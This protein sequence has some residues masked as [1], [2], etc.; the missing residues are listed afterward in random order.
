MANDLSPAAGAP[1][2]ATAGAPAAATAGAPATAAA[3]AG[4]P[5]TP[6]APRTPMPV[7]SLKRSLGRHRRRLACVLAALAAL[8]AVLA[9]AEIMLGNT[10]YPVRTVLDVLGGAQVTGAAYAIWEVRLPR[11]AAGVLAGFAFG[12]AGNTFQTMLRN[13]LASPDVIGITSGASVV[14]VACILV[15]H[16][17]AASA[18]LWAVLGGVLTAAAIFALATIGGFSI[19]KF[20]LVGLGVQAFMKAVVSYLL[21][22]GAEFDV[23]VALRWL[24]GSLS[25]TTMDDVGLLVAVVIPLA[26]LVMLLGRQL[27]VLELGNASA[28]MLGARPLLIRVTLVLC[29][30]V[31]IAFCT[32]VTGPIACVSLLAGPIATRLVG[33]ASS[34]TAAAG[35]VGVALVLAADLVGQYVL[36]TRFPVGVVTGILGTPYLLYLLVSMN[37]K[38]SA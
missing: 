21:L 16:M 22:K 29:C 27:K 38:G 14:A 34:S 12:V 33:Q 10:V 6:T 13:P 31:M 17:G 23:P 37:K 15:A 2:T 1:A 11:L 26:A 7:A 32:A 28:T 25:G 36:G 5:A 8:A 4:T 19:G 30:V 18:S 24:N 9:A 20:I 35:L 3:T